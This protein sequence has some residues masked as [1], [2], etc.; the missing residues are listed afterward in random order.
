MCLH[1]VGTQNIVIKEKILTVK[2]KIF[3]ASQLHQKIF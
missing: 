1:M 3:Q 2:K